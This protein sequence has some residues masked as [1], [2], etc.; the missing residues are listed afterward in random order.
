VLSPRHTYHSWGQWHRGF[1]KVERSLHLTQRNARNVRNATDVTQLTYSWRLQRPLLY[2]CV[3]RF[4]LELRQLRLLRTFLCSLLLLSA[5]VVACVALDGNYA[6]AWYS[7]DSYSFIDFTEQANIAT[8]F[9]ALRIRHPIASVLLS[10]RNVHSGC[11]VN[12]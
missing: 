4:L 10:P 1:K 6:L 2:P 9:S 11:H 5:F 7:I 8:C 3:S 12:E